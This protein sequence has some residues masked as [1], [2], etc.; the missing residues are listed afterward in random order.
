VD[1]AG[2]VSDDGILELCRQAY[3]TVSDRDLDENRLLWVMDLASYKQVRAAAVTEDQ[4]RA[5]AQAHA[6]AWLR[7]P[8]EAPYACPVCPSGPFGTMGELYGHVTI[9]ADP[10][11]REPDDHD[12]LF[13]IYIEVRDDGG[14]P[15]LEQRQAA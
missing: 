9:M 1:V 14:L 6:N 11:N 12:C 4:E 2:S 3:G 10:A 8:A 5:R 7:V 13:G 15:H